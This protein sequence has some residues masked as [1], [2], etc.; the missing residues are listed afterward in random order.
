MNRMQ[1]RSTMREFAG[2]LEEETGKLI[3]NL[4]MQQRGI[5][6]TFS[7]NAERIIGDAAETIK[8]VFRRH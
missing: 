5:R 3:G 7:A 1:V 4:E 6:K 8:A 2:K